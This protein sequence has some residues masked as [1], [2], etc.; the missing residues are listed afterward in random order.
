MRLRNILL[1]TAALS[2]LAVQ[3]NANLVVNGD[4]EA[5][6]FPV[7]S[8]AVVPP[9]TLTGWNVFGGTVAGIGVGYLSAPSQELDL[10]GITDTSGSGIDQS[11]ATVV[12]Q[13]YLVTFDVYTGNGGSIGAKIDGNLIVSG[14][15]SPAVRTP[16]TFNF[17]ASNA[18][19]NL[20]FVSEQGHITHIDNVSVES[21]PEPASMAV[22]GL[23]ALALR[24]K[25]K[26]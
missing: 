19:T 14:I 3:A 9:A 15:D 25:K 4:F 7:G 6:A 12:G 11:F 16:Y 24:R 5:D 1:T 2:V 10:S 17:V 22:L 8:F 20:A 23:G 18:S 21:V 26:A 13:Q